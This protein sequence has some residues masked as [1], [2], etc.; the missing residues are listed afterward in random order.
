MS[1]CIKVRSA[2]FVIEL[3]ITSLQMAPPVMDLALLQTLLIKKMYY[4]QIL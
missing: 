2:C 3:K 4:S 1:L